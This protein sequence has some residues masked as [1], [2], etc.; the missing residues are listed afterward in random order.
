[1][2][3]CRSVG[4]P[5]A[6]WSSSSDHV[7]GGGSAVFPRRRSCRSKHKLWSWASRSGAHGCPPPPPTHT[8]Q[9]KSHRGH[10]A[11]FA[12]RPISPGPGCPEGWMMLWPGGGRVGRVTEL[13]WKG[14]AR[15]NLGSVATGATPGHV[16]PCRRGPHTNPVSLQVLRATLTPCWWGAGLGG[17]AGEGGAGVGPADPAPSGRPPPGHLGSC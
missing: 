9:L 10:R 13:A 12:P 6:L 14:W 4:L 7:G 17:E 3:V 15:G 1:M 11:G 5:W 16:S 2:S 8:G